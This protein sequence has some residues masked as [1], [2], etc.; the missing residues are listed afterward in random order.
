PTAQLPPIG[1]IR[2]TPLQDLQAALCYLGSLY[3]PEV[4]PNRR[5]YRHAAQKPHSNLDAIRADAFERSYATRWL[6]ALVA[7]A[8]QLDVATEDATLDAEVIV[9]QAAG[10]L[11]LCAGTASAGTRSRVFA[12]AHPSDGAFIKVHLIDLPLDNQD[13][14]SLGAQTWGGACLMADLLVE[15]P[16]AF[17]LC[18]THGRPLRVLELGA[19]TGLVGLAASAA[20]AAHDTRADVVLTD[21]HTTVL[22]NL[23]SNAAANFPDAAGPVHVS[24]HPLD[25]ADTPLTAP[26]DHPFDVVLGADIVYELEHAHWIKACVERLLR[27]PPAESLDALASPHPAFHLVMPLRSTHAAESQTVEQVFP[28]ASSVRGGADSPPEGGPVATTL[29]IVAKEVV[30]CDD[31]ARG[32]GSE[33]EYVHF[34]IAW[35]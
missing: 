24:V 22:E 9:Q 30:V 35:V 20:L 7:R 10:L 2:Q 6:T 21:F 33:V 15:S 26:F 32:S 16:P 1:R 12:F 34:T 25:W 14:T 8:D 11:A 4:R 3:N 27:V 19:G 13:Y 17:A 31:F 29:A 23:R 5:S 18:P 28:S